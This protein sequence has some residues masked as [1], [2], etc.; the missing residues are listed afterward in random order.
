MPSHGVVDV[1][2][3]AIVDGIQTMIKRG[4]SDDYIRKVVGE[5]AQPEV[6]DHHRRVLQGH[7][8]KPTHTESELREME[9]KKQAARD[10]MAKA[11]AA[12]KTKKSVAEE[13]K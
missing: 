10:R 8:D 2:H 11:R 6:I 13:I 9:E 3:P 4:Y 1:E 7:Y 5:A 12:R